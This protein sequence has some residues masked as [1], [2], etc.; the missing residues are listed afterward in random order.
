MTKNITT[1]LVNS[2]LFNQHF[3]DTEL[4][5]GSTLTGSVSTQNPHHHNQKTVKM[6]FCLI[7]NSTNDFNFPPTLTELFS[8]QLSR[9]LSFDLSYRF[10]MWWRWKKDVLNFEPN[11]S[12]RSK[13]V[14]IRWSLFD[15]LI[16]FKSFEVK[17]SIEWD[18]SEMKICLSFRFT[19]F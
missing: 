7:S 14:L 9:L 10:P 4:H 19:R 8:L 1:S 5:F 6:T 13:K 12:K 11:K 18:L 3:S 2:E 16:M 15:L 17:K